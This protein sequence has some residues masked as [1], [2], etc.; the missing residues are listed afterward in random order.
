M[1]AHGWFWVVLPALSLFVPAVRHG[2]DSLMCI[3]RWWMWDRA[4][5][6]HGVKVSD[7]RKL[8]LEAAQSDLA[9][10]RK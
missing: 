6:R 1:S 5:R 8:L 10:N 7:R 2:L 9:A 3:A 4:A